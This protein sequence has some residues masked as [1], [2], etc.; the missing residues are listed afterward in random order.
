VAGVPTARMAAATRSLSD[1][2][3]SQSVSNDTI[4]VR[5]RQRANALCRSPYC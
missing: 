3:K 1:G 4:S 2:G 5:P